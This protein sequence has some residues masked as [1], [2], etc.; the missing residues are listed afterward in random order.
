MA[1]RSEKPLVLL[2][3]DDV[4]ATALMARWLSKGGL[5]TESLSSAEALLD[6]FKLSLPDVVCLDLGL[7]GMGGLEA[8]R[9]VRSRHRTVPIVVVTGDDTVDS[10][11]EAMAAGAYDY[12]TKPVS[13]DRLTTAVRNAAELHQTSSQL[14][15][16][17]GEQEGKTPKGLVGES[18][19]MK[20]V[21]RQLAKISASDITV[22]V[23][24]ESGTGKELVARAVHAG[25]PRSKGPFVAINCAAVPESLQD[26]EFFG[27]EKGAFTG[28]ASAKA[29]RFEEAHGGTLF[30]DEVGELSPSLQAKLLRVLQERTFRRVGG[31]QELR[32]DFRLLAATHRDLSAMVEDG[33]FRGDLF[34]RLAVLE[35]ELP[36]LRER[37]DDRW[38]LVSTWLDE[39]EREDIVFDK[40]VRRA[41]D[42]YAWPGNVRELLNVVERAL[43]LCEDEQIRLGDI[44]SRV[45]QGSETSTAITEA[46]LEAMTLEELERWA[47]ERAMARTNGNL[48]EVIRMLGIGRTT[49]YRKL[50]RYGYK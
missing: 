24:G 11:V 25:S 6:A 8:L 13:R 14:A 42:T 46:S 19:A 28:A 44:P 22:L 48:G 21:F 32:S 15:A 26:A 27:H 34:Y 4:D 31:S 33:T 30:L 37:G 2:V 40:D 20:R 47:I 36:P 1:K 5:R 43:V 49:L 29:G 23:H 9:L 18:P 16:F 12:L 41:F 10:A 45:V 38:R 39:R 3:D 35:L 7:P 50:K 17:E